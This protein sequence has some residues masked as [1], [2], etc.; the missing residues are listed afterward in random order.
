LE[1]G[2][3]RPWLQKGHD[4]GGPGIGSEEALSVAG[5][6]GRGG[7]RGRGGGRGGGGGPRNAILVEAR[8]PVEGR[9]F[10]GEAD[11]KLSKFGCMQKSICKTNKN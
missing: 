8:R 10:C 7:R 4:A 5:A 9:T 6:V 1:I 2:E 11:V 3:L